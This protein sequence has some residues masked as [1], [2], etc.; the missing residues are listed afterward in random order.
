MVSGITLLIL[1]FL[2]PLILGVAA[3]LACV[4]ARRRI[5]KWFLAAM[6]LLS[7]AFVAWLAWDS[8]PYLYAVYLEEQWRAAKPK[9]K[10][11]L[12]SHLSLYREQAIDPAQSDWGRYHELKPDERMVQY[13]I[14]GRAPLDVVYNSSNDI[15]AIYTSYE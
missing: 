12:E 8:T 11:E 2:A 1:L 3:A 6:A 15:V 10:T 4:Q 7:L 14:L 9:T 13:L 5:L